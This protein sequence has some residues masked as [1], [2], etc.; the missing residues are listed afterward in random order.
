MSELPSLEE[1][2]GTV[3]E[4]ARTR[5]TKHD[6]VSARHRRCMRR[7]SA[8]PRAQVTRAAARA[9]LLDLFAVHGPLRLMVD[10][11]TGRRQLVRGSSSSLASEV[12]R[13][14]QAQPRRGG[15]ESSRRGSQS[16]GTRPDG[17]SDAGFELAR[18]DLVLRPEIWPAGP[19][20]QRITRS[21]R[22]RPSLHG[23]ASKHVQTRRSCTRMHDRTRRRGGG[24]CR[25]D[26]GDS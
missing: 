25:G 4:E 9:D 7:S 2:V 8:R 17:R 14:L 19:H 16:S 26:L 3:A 15:R 10:L 24:A 1:H 11:C 18:C 13:I 20:L 23:S 21:P 12:R 5:S 22:S 6:D